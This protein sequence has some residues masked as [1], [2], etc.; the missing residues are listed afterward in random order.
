MLYMI[1]TLQRVGNKTD[2]LAPDYPFFFI[3]GSIPPFSGMENP[4]FYESIAYHLHFCPKFQFLVFGPISIA[5]TSL[6]GCGQE[7][8]LNEGPMLQ[9][10]SWSFYT[11]R[12]NR[13][14][15]IAIYWG[16]KLICEPP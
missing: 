16:K 8:G 7:A 15:L 11:Y 1:I 12:S 13:L 14:A 2:I 5:H 6:K 9:N 3:F 10:F 4:I